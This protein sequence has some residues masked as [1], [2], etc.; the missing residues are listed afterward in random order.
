MKTGQQPFLVRKIKNWIATSLCVISVII[1]ITPLFLILFYMISHGIGVI[2][3]DFLTKMP[4]PVGEAGGGMA[5]ALVGTGILL[6]IGGLIGL[7]V[8]IM[9]ALYLASE[10]K[11][12]FASLVRYLT[13]VLSGIPSIVVGVVAYVLVVLPMKHFSAL[14]GGVALGILI[15]PIVIRTTEEM[16]R[17][18]PSILHEGALALGITQWK[19][20]LWIIFPAALK[21]ITTGILLALA[22]AAGET[23]PLLFTALGNRF[24]STSVGQ[25]IASLTVFIFDYAKAPFEDW[26]QQ[27]WAAALVLIAFIFSLNLLFRW[28]TRGRH[29]EH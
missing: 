5:N 22:R 10:R 28:V 4:K 21:G 13:E 23:A 27:A 20:T 1:T 14:A 11:N 15:I 19:T 29:A 9:T 17:L 16:I 24:W 3:I 25:P 8:G 7:P 2:S 12:I 6:G 18:V 26:N